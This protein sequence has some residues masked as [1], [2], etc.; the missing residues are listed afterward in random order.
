LIDGAIADQFMASIKAKLEGWE[1][2]L[3]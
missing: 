1:E 2:K 3:F